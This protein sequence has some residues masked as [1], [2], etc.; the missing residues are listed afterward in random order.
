MRYSRQRELVLN[1]VKASFSHPTAEEVYEQAKAVEPSISLGTVYRN[2]KC[3][4]ENGDLVTLETMDKKLHYDGHVD[5]H[6]HF[7]CKKCGKI[8]DLYVKSEIPEELSDASFVV[9]DEK[10]IYYGVCS[11]CLK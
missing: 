7:I 2:L 3:L 8:V 11:D 1:L 5:S 10:C 6:R 4:A 9:E